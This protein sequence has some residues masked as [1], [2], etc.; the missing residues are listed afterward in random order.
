[1]LGASF[2]T[3]EKI[4]KLE[5]KI[6][7]LKLLKGELMN[8]RNAMMQELDTN[9]QRVYELEELKELKSNFVLLGKQCQLAESSRD[10]KE[11][12]LADIAGKEFVGDI[13][14]AA[15]FYEVDADIVRVVKLLPHCSS[16]LSRVTEIICTILRG[17]CCLFAPGPTG[18]NR[19][20]P[21]V[22]ELPAFFLDIEDLE[23]SSDE[24]ELKHKLNGG[25][26]VAFLG[27]VLEV[28]NCDNKVF[29]SSWAL[30]K[31]PK[32]SIPHW[33]NDLYYFLGV[34]PYS[35]PGIPVA[36]DFLIKRVSSDVR[37]INPLVHF[38]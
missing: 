30:G 24:A 3:N 13:L 14:K 23:E 5:G 37:S 10:V 6:H 22:S 29:L 19:L 28:V 36:N 1:M 15:S 20:G 31:G 16:T 7:D 11:G 9:R 2:A 18:D 33:T 25:S 12:E 35:L 4:K 34:L 26:P 38:S 32:R 8:V 27:K 17:K 21:T